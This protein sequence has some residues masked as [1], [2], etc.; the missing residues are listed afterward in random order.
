M[1]PSFGMPTEDL[2]SLIRGLAKTAL[3]V[4]GTDLSV[5]GTEIY[6]SEEPKSSRVNFDLMNDFYC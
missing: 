6:P 5:T 2:P 4:K 3:S 1:G